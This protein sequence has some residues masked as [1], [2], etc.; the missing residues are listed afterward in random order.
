MWM[1]MA[2]VHSGNL[3]IT[4]VFSSGWM[5]KQN[6][7]NGSHPYNGII[8]S[9]RKEWSTD[10][11]IDRHRHG[12]TVQHSAERGQAEKA[13]VSTTPC[14]WSVQNRQIYRD[15]KQPSGCHRLRSGGMEGDSQWG[16][17]FFGGKGDK[18]CPGK[19]EW[20][21]LYHAVNVLSV[22]SSKC[23]AYF[24]LIET[25]FKTYLWIELNFRTEKG[26]SGK[27]GK[28]KKAWH[29][30][31]S[32]VPVGFLVVTMC[33]SHED[34]N[35]GQ[36][37]VRVWI[38][39]RLLP[40]LQLFCKPKMIPKW[41]IYSRKSYVTSRKGPAWSPEGSFVCPR[42]RWGSDLQFRELGDLFGRRRRIWSSQAQ[43]RRMRW[44][45]GDGEEGGLGK[46][47]SWAGGSPM[48]APCWG[49]S[50][51]FEDRKVSTEA[52]NG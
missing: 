7:Q 14:I 27:T 35:I 24:I 21:W 30:T 43:E 37:W 12:W 32:A 17:G 33:P 18:K 22:I 51:N 48:E 42:T 3:K 50:K 45:E 39:Q 36:S 38:Q 41:I 11:G 44:R 6:K 52:A 28:S 23:Y 47:W 9:H 15:R 29:F 1:F 49:N 26:H 25:I 13:T 16:P 4:Q 19:R 5:D 31:A 20:W 46:E 8:F 2:A 34:A 10:T 40:S